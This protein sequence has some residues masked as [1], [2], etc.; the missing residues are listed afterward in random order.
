MGKG[1]A[2]AGGIAALAALRNPAAAAKY[3]GSLKQVVTNPKAAL[4]RGWR[5]GATNITKGP[6]A[7]G[8]ASKRVG[9]YKKVLSD[10]QGGKLLSAKALDPKSSRGSNW[11]SVGWSKGK[12]LKMDK[13]LSGKVESTLVRLKAGKTVPEAELRGL[14]HRLQSVGG[15]QGLKMRKTLTHYMPGERALFP[16][17]GMAGGVAGGAE[18]HDAETGRKRGIG[19]R[20]AR[21]A[22]GA[23][24]G[25]ALAPAFLGRGMGLGK[26]SV[27]GGKKPGGLLAQKMVLPIAAS[28]VAFGAGDVATDVA[29]GGGRLVDK[30]FGQ[31]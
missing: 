24:M 6:G 25:A 14:Y 16:G 18:T 20:L 30:A 17:L 21:G 12:G 4:T 2:I 29:S 11:L 8:S 26:A 22:A 10:A 19:E 7:S 28:T 13:D 31:K 3:M 27:L 23:Y 9:M 5:E 15:A 1:T